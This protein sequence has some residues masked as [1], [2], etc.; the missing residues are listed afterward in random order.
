MLEVLGIHGFPRV[1]K[2]FKYTTCVFY[3]PS[4]PLIFTVPIKY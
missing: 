2:K 4:F 3:T 1:H